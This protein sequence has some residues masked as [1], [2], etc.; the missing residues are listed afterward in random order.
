MKPI[1]NEAG[2]ESLCQA[3]VPASPSLCRLPSR[4]GLR[5]TGSFSAPA[6]SECVWKRLCRWPRRFYR[7]YYLNIEKDHISPVRNYKSGFHFLSRFFSPLQTLGKN[8]TVIYDMQE[9]FG[10][11]F[12]TPLALAHSLTLYMHAY[13]IYLHVLYKYPQTHNHV[14]FIYT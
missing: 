7:K 6:A 8:V 11:F 9:A 13:K 14:F 4:G 1:T 5:L 3:A 2:V 12:N 10:N